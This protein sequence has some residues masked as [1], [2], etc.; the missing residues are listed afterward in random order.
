M[1]NAELMSD[2]IETFID[3]LDEVEEAEDREVTSYT[4]VT[5]GN[6]DA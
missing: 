1:V 6:L 4:N 5:G 2:D 3:G